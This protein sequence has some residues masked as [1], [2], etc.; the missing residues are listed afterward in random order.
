[1]CMC[2]WHVDDEVEVVK[3]KK[4]GKRGTVTTVHSY[5]TWKSTVLIDGVHY[6]LAGS[7]L[8]RVGRL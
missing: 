8:K 4:K 1:M 6:T 5:R 2:R 3:G 7:T